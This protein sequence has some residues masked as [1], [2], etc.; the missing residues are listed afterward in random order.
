MAYPR[1]LMPAKILVDCTRGAIWKAFRDMLLLL[2]RRE[3]RLRVDP[4]GRSKEATGDV[5]SSKSKAIR[6]DG[7][8]WS[9]GMCMMILPFGRVVLVLLGWK[10]TRDVWKII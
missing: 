9:N 6:A 3:G 4:S 5:V 2:L 1:K 7:D 8:L 10:V